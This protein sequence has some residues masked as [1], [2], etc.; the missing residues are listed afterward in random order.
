VRAPRKARVKLR[1]ARCQFSLVGMTGWTTIK[2]ELRRGGKVHAAGRV[3]GWRGRASLTLAA[4]RR[5]AARAY[6]L[7]LRPAGR[8]PVRLRVRLP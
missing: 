4:R 7:V 1:S 5:L 2:A 6:T 3:L 8:T